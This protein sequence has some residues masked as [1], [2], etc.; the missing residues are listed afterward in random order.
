MNVENLR[1]EETGSTNQVEKKP[2]KLKKITSDSKTYNLA[3]R[4]RLKA[5]KECTKC[6]GEPEEEPFSL[7][8]MEGWKCG[9]CFEVLGWRKI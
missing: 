9:I 7:P 5:I 6:G 1:T 8:T 4:Q 2:R 3:K